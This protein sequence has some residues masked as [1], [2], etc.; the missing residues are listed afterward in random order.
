MEHPL[1]LHEVER[2][3]CVLVVEGGPDFLA[4][5]H[6]ITL[7]DDARHYGV[8]GMLGA[9]QDSPLNKQRCSKEADTNFPTHG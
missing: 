7:T 1:G 9:S 8:I 4:A 5:N 6:L 2:H 3:K